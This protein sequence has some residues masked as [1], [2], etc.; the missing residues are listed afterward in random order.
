[1]RGPCEGALSRENST[2]PSLWS[3]PLEGLP[4]GLLHCGIVIPARFM[5]EMG[6]FCPIRPLWRWRGMSAMPARVT[7]FCAAQQFI[8]L[9]A[10][11]IIRDRGRCRHGRSTAQQ[12]AKRKAWLCYGLKELHREVAQ[13]RSPH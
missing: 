6:H 5:A 1:M 12:S 10:S 9:L 11:P 13:R 3:L 8:D 4:D 2:A 7:E